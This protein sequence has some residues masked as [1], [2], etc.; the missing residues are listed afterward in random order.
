MGEKSQKY[1]K[2]ERNESADKQSTLRN[3]IIE[4][5]L[6]LERLLKKK[7]KKKTTKQTKITATWITNGKKGKKIFDARMANEFMRTEKKNRQQR[8]ES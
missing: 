8:Q 7:K 5:P 6:A 3:R 1:R 2:N 4:H